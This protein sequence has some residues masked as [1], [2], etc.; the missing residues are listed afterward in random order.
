M[1]GETWHCVNAAHRGMAH[2]NCIARGKNEYNTTTIACEPIIAGE[3][4]V[5]SMNFIAGAWEG[6]SRVFTRENPAQPAETVAVYPLSGKD[7]AVRA[8]AA[9]EA[10]FPRWKAT[11]LIERARILQRAARNLEGRLEETAQL[12]AREVGKPIGEAR[13]EVRRAVDLLEYYAAFA[14]Q[15]E[16]YVVAS[17]RP[18]TELR[19]IRIPLGVIALVTPWNFPIAIPTWK[20]APALILGNTV[21]LKPASPGPGGAIALV[22][23]LEQ[24]GLPPGVVNLV[25][26]PGTP[27]G[28]ALA[29]TAALRA[30]SFT[31]S[32]E[33]GTRLKA[34]LAERLARVQLELGGKNPFVVWEDADL[35][36]AARLAAEGAFF[37][38]GQKCTAT[39]RV[40]VHHT[41]YAPFRERFVAATQA[42]A[43]GD[44]RDE[45]TRIG[46]LIDPVSHRNVVHWTARG[47]ADGGTLLTGGIAPDR[48]GYFFAPTIID[49]LS[50]DAPLAQ[51]EV[52]GPLVT[53]HPV[54]D[55]A[56]AIAAANATR[57]GLSASISTRSLEIAEGFL[58]GCDAGLVHVNQP[59]AGVEYQAPF[60]GARASGFGGKEQSW[61]ALDFYGDW[62]TQ[63]VR[64]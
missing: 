28:Q 5:E 40:L 42:L 33:V 7:E 1:I 58:A 20:L 8:F 10:A 47:V 29:E 61:A 63:V 55:L 45:T 2:S 18:R 26:G 12:L 59:T 9:A 15:P 56:S 32:V 62:K 57:F 21:V 44:P 24:A 6:T 35:D 16:G 60:G 36:E 41:V 27:F 19:A 51:E 64:I 37:Y 46:P 3:T 30:V 38:A 22:R 23:A 39:S 34:T 14:W 48:P 17:A 53:M 25:I 4:A 11:P 43:L 13:G 31:G 50:L 52:F 49:G 54:N